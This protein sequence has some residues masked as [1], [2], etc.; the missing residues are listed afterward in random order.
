MVK[1]AAVFAKG[2]V[3]GEVRYAPF[4]NI[5]DEESRRE[6]KKFNI[7]PLG[8]IA[9]YPR[10]IPYNSDKKRFLEKT[11]R[12]SFE[13]FQYTFKVPGE[14]SSYNVM[15]DYNIG[16][17]RITPF[18]KCCKY[19]KTTPAKMLNSN[20]GLRD[21]CHSITGGA[22]AAQG[23]WMP[24][25]AAKAMAATF[26][27]HIRYALVPL[28][29]PDFI[30]LCYDP[31]D[32]SFGHMIIDKEI[33]R[34]CTTGAQ[35]FRA[36]EEDKGCLKQSL[37]LKS[38]ETKMPCANSKNGWTS[39]SLRN[40]GKCGLYTESGYCT[41]TDT[42]EKCPIFPDVASEEAWKAGQFQ[43]GLS[44]VGDVLRAPVSEWTPPTPSTMD[45]A[46]NV[47]R[48]KRSLADLD[49]DY[50][51]DDTS[52]DQSSSEYTIPR[53]KRRRSSGMTEEAKAAY[54]LM[55]LHVADAALGSSGGMIR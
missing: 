28:F 16:L 39:K 44:K 13:V 34:Q 47:A 7:Y 19:S 1:D 31:K 24:Y 42:S 32:S 10:H 4:Q 54:I 11:G 36:M 17:V 55:R 40:G 27:Y 14:A 48:A 9:E 53:A 45:G 25:E 18:F 49:E 20:P 33:I 38:S 51:D 26:C 52:T 6:M 5:D 29:G 15:W 8:R 2:N 50:E 3:K 12:E 23:Y 37:S 46:L 41:D 30:S 35:D 43:R 21:V 22:L